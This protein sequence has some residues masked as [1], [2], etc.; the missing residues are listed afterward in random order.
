MV[1]SRTSKSI[2]NSIV[3]LTMY[4]VNLIL[5]FYS[6]KVFLEY[7]GSEILGLNTTATNILQFLNLAELGI[8]SAIAFS[9]Y[10]PLHLKD[11]D[12]VNRIVSF[13]GHIYRRIAFVIIASAMI[14]MSFFP[15]IFEKIKVPLWYAYATFSVLLFSSLLGYFA[16]YKQLV[17]SADQ[18]D[19]KIQ[20]SYKL[21]MLVKFAAQILALKLLPYPYIC[22]LSLEFLFTITGAVA[23]NK[24][25]KKTYPFLKQ[26]EESFK[27]LR[28]RYSELLLK[29]KQLFVQKISGYVMFQTSPIIIYGL[30][31]LTSVTLYGNYHLIIQGLIS[32]LAAMFNSIVAGI[33]NLIVSSSK[34]HVLD[35]FFQLFSI[36]FYIISILSF[37]TWCIGQ[38]FIHWW[39]G[40]EYVLSNS[41]LLIMIL[42]FFFYTNRYIV[43]DYLSAYGYFGDVWAS[44]L[45]VVLNIGLSIILGIKYGL[46]GVLVGALISMVA[47]SFLWKP[48][49]LFKI[50]LHAGYGKFWLSNLILILPLSVLLVISSLCN[51]SLTNSILL[52]AAIKIVI[53]SILLGLSFFY[54]FNPFRKCIKRFI[55]I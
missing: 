2:K 15:L 24:V 51:I 53:F 3:A 32:L 18:R 36:R 50:K 7:L 45:E 1:E 44:V 12:E 17:L 22:W 6:R 41:T 34:K 29:I 9:L 4:F 20:L 16:N 11:F 31:S 30:S 23:L 27:E 13:N 37:S 39:I 52:D 33:G 19:Y 42:T 43:Y 28:V 54:T 8:G 38:S 21:T 49:Y 10:K 55:R 48:F 14:I 5:Q 26:T 40:E 35:V 25:I 47:I 46:N